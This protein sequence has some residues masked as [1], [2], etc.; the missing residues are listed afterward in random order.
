M[1]LLKEYYKRG[2]ASSPSNYNFE[3]QNLRMNKNTKINRSK[4]E[5]F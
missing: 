5:P 2:S 1:E 3:Y 4:H